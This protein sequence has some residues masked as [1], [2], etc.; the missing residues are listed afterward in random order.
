MSESQKERERC[1]GARFSAVRCE[2]VCD[3]SV[4]DAS[5]SDAGHRKMPTSAASVM[6]GGAMRER[7]ECVRAAR[8]Y[9]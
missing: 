2:A 3:A 1:P 6:R 4:S 5:V 7:E 8:S 9:G